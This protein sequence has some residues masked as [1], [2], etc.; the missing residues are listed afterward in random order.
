MINL[1]IKC[2]QLQ[3]RKK[4]ETAQYAHWV[5][6]HFGQASLGEKAKIQSLTSTQ[7]V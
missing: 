6:E 3:R 4:L 5:W 2:L 7:S 1:S